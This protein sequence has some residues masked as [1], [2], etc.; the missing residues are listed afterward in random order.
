MPNITPPDLAGREPH[1]REERALVQ[2]LQHGDESAFATVVERYH[3]SMLRLATARVGDPQLAEEI[4]QDAWLALVRGIGQ[5][6][7]RASLKTWL[8]RVVMYR[9]R[10]RSDRERRSVPFSRFEDEPDDGARFLPEDHPRWPGHWAEA[11]PE[12]ETAPEA[13]LLRQET[14]D[15]LKHLIEMLPPRY[16]MVLIL[17]DIEGL[18]A[19]DVC[20]ILSL[21][22]G[23]ERVLLHR[24]RA[25]IRQGMVDYLQEGDVGHR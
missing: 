16:R 10:A 15:W 8:F 7:E 18:C 2:A 11:V 4:V 9:A 13:M 14:M 6:E 1:D 24:A 5:F 12:V 25:K 19:A 3:A 23:V 20:D 22:D 17:R 21:T